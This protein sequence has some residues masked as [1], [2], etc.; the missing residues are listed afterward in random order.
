M[1]VDK[2]QL[3]VDTIVGEIDNQVTLSF[4]ATCLSGSIFQS[5]G[6]LNATGIVTANSFVGDGSQLS[7]ISIAQIGPVIGTILIQ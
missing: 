7:G 3:Q 2:S 5:L 4:G 6:G 1:S